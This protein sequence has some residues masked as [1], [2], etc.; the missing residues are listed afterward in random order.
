[1]LGRG[2]VVT[3]CAP[4]LRAAP[5]AC[6]RRHALLAA[7]RGRCSR[8]A[9]AGQSF[10]RC[11]GFRL[12]GNLRWPVGGGCEQDCKRAAA[13][14]GRGLG[15]GLGGVLVLDCWSVGLG[16]AIRLFETGDWGD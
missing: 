13:G 8:R 4:A 6:A 16:P 11:A 2:W 9:A 15:L 12:D 5:C 3:R 14:T 7:G 10:P 1:V